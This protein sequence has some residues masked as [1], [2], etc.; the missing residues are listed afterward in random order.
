[1]GQAG[2]PGLG[3]GRLSVL[4]TDGED[5]AT[6]TLC[7]SQARAGEPGGLT[8]PA[9]LSEPLSALTRPQTGAGL[10][11]QLWDER[12]GTDEPTTNSGDLEGDTGRDQAALGPCW[13][14]D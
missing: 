6:S 3:R 14:L 10:Q 7:P 9:G 13:D 1:M 5:R 11:A 4:G 8:H 12:E 2:V